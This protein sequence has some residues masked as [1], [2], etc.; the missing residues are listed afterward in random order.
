MLNA[1]VRAQLGVESSDL[2]VYLEIA[3]AEVVPA[4]LKAH[5]LNTRSGHV[6]FQVGNALPDLGDDEVLIKVEVLPDYIRQ[7]SDCGKMIE[8]GLRQVFVKHFP[9][10]RFTVELTEGSVGVTV[11]IDPK[12]P[13]APYREMSEAV[14]AAQLLIA[15]MID[16]A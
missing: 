1:A 12:E 10:L 14:E 6:L 15:S 4:A 11:G 9:H 3:C 7:L 2:G 8:D 16:C 5:R 13:T